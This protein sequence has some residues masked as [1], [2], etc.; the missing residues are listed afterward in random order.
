[1]RD[2]EMTIKEFDKKL[3]EMPDEELVGMAERYV[4]DTAAF[5]DKYFTMSVP[6]RVTDADMVLCELIRRYK[7][8]AGVAL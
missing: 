5:G 8:K 3:A 4:M 6:P 7:N 2:H 1:M